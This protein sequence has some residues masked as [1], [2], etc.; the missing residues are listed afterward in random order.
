MHDTPRSR[1]RTALHPR[2]RLRRL[3]RLCGLHRR[4]AVDWRRASSPPAASPPGR[5][6]VAKRRYGDDD[7]G[8]AL[9]LSSGLPPVVTAMLAPD[10]YAAPPDAVELVQ[11]HISYV[12][13][14]GDDVYKLKKPVRF[15]FLD[16]STLERRRHFCHEE[17]RLNRRLARRR[18]PRACSRSSRATAASRSR[19][20]TRPARSS[21]PCTCAACQPS[22]CCRTCSTRAP[23]TTRSIDRI[24]ARVAAF[25]AG[26]DTDAEIARGGDPAIDRAADGRRLRRGR[27]RCTATPS[28]RRRRGHPALVSR[29]PPRA[30]T[31]CCAAARPRAASATATATCTPS[32]SRSPHGHG[33]PRSGN[34][35]RAGH[36]RLHR[37]QPRLPPSRR[38]GGD[39]VS[40]DGSRVPRPAR[41]RR[42]AWSRRTRALAADPD[43]PELVPFYACQRA[44][45]RG[46]VDSLKS[47]RPRSTRPS[48]AAARDERHRAT[49]RWRYR[50][51]WAYAPRPG[52]GR[53]GS[54]AAASR[55]SRP[56]CRSAPA[57][58]TQFRRTR[59]RL[60]GLR[61]TDAR[62]APD[63]LHRRSAARRRTRRCTPPRAT[64]S[65]PAAAR[66][67]TPPSSAA[68]I[69]MRARAIAD[70]PASRFSSSNAAPPRP[71]CAGASPPAPRATTIRPTPTGRSTAASGATTS[72]SPP[73]RSRT[74]A[75]T[76]RG[77]WR[78]IVATI[79]S[80]AA[81]S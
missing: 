8:P 45:I 2:P 3:P 58:R 61:P 26:A 37:V 1:V 20:R 44:Y 35:R 40:G 39:R 32:T 49:S 13:L 54:A 72:R 59:K 74:S 22:A 34:R 19:P 10:F 9:P 67:S 75:S 41:S 63:A 77:R 31:R 73:T 81:R 48:A 80:G 62:P 28:R 21:T 57:S 65:P 50:Y 55:R 11:T 53:A 66:S 70:A 36:L 79:E 69:A 43:L 38:R 56:R 23:S 14:A 47:A 7:S 52:R 5:G 4:V 60:A 18:L 46:K 17:V 15:A 42:R 6:I 68:S 25:H 51:T 24:A 33:G 76:R 30:T 27:S 71:R 12:L 16:F 64:R 78:E 29:P